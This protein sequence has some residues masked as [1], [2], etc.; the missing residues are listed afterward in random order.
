MQS[1]RDRIR[2]KIHGI[3]PNR[4]KAD[5]FDVRYYLISQL[6]Q[7]S[8]KT[9]LDIGG[10]IGIIS[11]EMDKSNFRIVMDIKFSDLVKCLRKID[12]SINP[13]CASF[14]DL[15]FKDDFFQV[16]NSSHIIE[17]TR[18]MDV[19][20]GQNQ[21]DEGKKFPTVKKYLLEMYRVLKRGGMVYLT[22]P[23]NAYYKGNKFDYEE[24]KNILSQIFDENKILFYNT[25][26]RYSKNRKFDMTNVLPKIKSKFVNSDKIISELIKKESENNFSKYFYCELKKL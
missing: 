13:V 14:T 4:W 20:N 6:K 21:V 17:M 26:P 18:Y 2:N 3:S 10:G 1:E 5:E 12:P 15:P 23:N 22:T 9:V 16:V 25:Y 24:L 11:S 19:K 8:D 7:I